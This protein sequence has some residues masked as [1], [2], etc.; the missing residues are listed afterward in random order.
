MC[1]RSLQHGEHGGPGD[2]V[3]V[4][5]REDGSLLYQG[6]PHG[7]RAVLGL[8]VQEGGTVVTGGGREVCALHLPGGGDGAICRLGLSEEGVWGVLERKEWPS[9]GEVTYFSSPP[10][11]PQVTHLHC[12][13]GRAVVGSRKEARLWDLEQ[14]QLVEGVK[15]VPVKV[16]KV[17][18]A[19]PHVFLVGGDDWQGVQVISTLLN[20][21][22][23]LL[24]QP[25]PATFSRPCSPL[26]CR[27]GTCWSTD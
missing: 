20:P 19:F 7:Q 6:R 16:W 26:C 18:L 25:T 23:V 3:S 21:R 9:R 1:S 22:L 12:E 4:W 24:R 27:C 5:D 8:G 15:P 13:G 10:P 11:A 14:G 17:C 2:L